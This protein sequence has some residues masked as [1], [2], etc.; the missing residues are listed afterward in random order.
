[1]ARSMQNIPGTYCYCFNYVAGRLCDPIGMTWAPGNP[2]Y[3]PGPPPPPKS[4]KPP[5]P[6][7]SVP[8]TSTAKVK[9]ASQ[10]TNLATIKEPAKGTLDAS[11]RV[12]SGGVSK[13][14]AS[15]GEK[16]PSQQRRR[17]YSHRPRVPGARSKRT[18]S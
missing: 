18:L 12:A 4:I 1:M 7:S 5:T 3:D 2:D 10:G 11:P 14:R 13:L 16:Q 9:P 15:H 17:G 6:S 8:T